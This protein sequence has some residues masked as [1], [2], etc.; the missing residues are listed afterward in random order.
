MHIFKKI[1]KNLTK[2]SYEVLIDFLN[3]ENNEDVEMIDGFEDI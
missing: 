3:Q 2:D 1:S